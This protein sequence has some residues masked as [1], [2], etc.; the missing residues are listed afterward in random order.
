VSQLFGDSA[1]RAADES[2][3]RQTPPLVLRLLGGL[4]VGSAPLGELAA[5]RQPTSPSANAGLAGRHHVQALLAL[6][7]SSA[8]GMGRDELVELLW[9]KQGA[10]AGRNRLYHTVHLARQALSQQAWD[11]EWV[12]VRGGR[13]ALDERVWCDV[14]AL[15]RVTPHSVAG[16]SM[17]A[18]HQ[19]LSLCHGDWM[20]GLELGEAGQQVR[21]RVRQAQARVLREAVLRLRDHGDSPALRA[22]LHKLLRIEATDEPSYRELMA[23]DLHA[24]RW[25][26]VLRTYE[27]VCRELSALLG[28]RPTAAT[29][30]I[31]AAASARLQQV[32]LPPLREAGAQL[33]LGRE[34]VVQDLVQQMSAAPGV[35]NVTGLSGIG[36]TSLL[37]EVARRLAPAMPDGVQFIGM[38]DLS[39]DDTAAAACVRALGMA[40]MSPTSSTSPI[41][42]SDDLNALGQAL[43]VRQMLL[44]LDDLDAAADAPQLLQALPLPTQA[45]LVVVSRAPLLSGQAAWV[46]MQVQVPVA[47]LDVPAEHETLD[48]ARHRAGY[49]LFMLRCAS[50]GSHS[51]SL[52]WQQEVAQLVSRLDGLPLAIELAAARTTTLTP[53]EILRQIEAGQRPLEH[54]PLNLS[55]RHRSLQSSLDWTTQLLQPAVR[56]AYAA[57]SVFPAVFQHADALAI[58]PAVG[59][60]PAHMADALSELLHVGLLKPSADEQALRMLHLPREHARAIAVRLGHWAPVVQARLDELGRQLDGHLLQPESPLYTTQLRRVAELEADALALLEHARSHAAAL[61]LRILMPLCEFWITRSLT[62]V[63]LHWTERALAVAQN[64]QDADAELWFRAAQAQALQRSGRLIDAERLSQSLPPLIE[65]VSNPMGV[66]HAVAIWATALRGTGQSPRAVS[67]CQRTLQ[68]LQLK[69]QDRGF[70]TLYERLLMMRAGAAELPLD[71]AALRPRFAGSSLWMNLLDTAFV[72]GAMDED[73]GRQKAIAQEMIAASQALRQHRF[74]L[75]GTWHL[76]ACELALDRTDEAVRTLDDY[77]ICAR[78]LGWH[79]G[80]ARAQHLTALLR[81]RQGRPEAAL[82]CIT[83]V[84]QHQQQG[85]HEGL[86]VSLPLLRSRLLVQTDRTDEAMREWLAAPVAWLQRATDEHLVD[87]SETGALIAHSLGLAELKNEL[88]TAMRLL[89]GADDHIPIIRRDR[90]ARFGPGPARMSTESTQIESLRGRV[91]AAV[92]AL[93]ECLLHRGSVASH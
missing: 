85:T 17:A 93:R 81:L 28:L 39:P 50:S 45:R 16:L 10:S 15:E 86:V 13:V 31:A 8:S 67:L 20:P 87:W 12:V 70:W 49:A 52:A 36:K 7:G 3:Q 88:A 44:V 91:R 64:L 48:Q 11:D 19:L 25:H 63:V 56:A 72:M 58:A 34:S 35:W 68:Q 37:R 33:L 9:P 71:L 21:L 43:Q 90:D 73:W 61:F 54:G 30:A 18:L 69:P 46:Q 26:A 6:A 14:Q 82:P 27:A 32:E 84:E 83:V 38:G 78:G 51:P 2:L 92:T 53:G 75:S 79:K 66:A 89:D 40:P 55:P 77:Y 47:A 60:S 41:T 23:L 22:H 5:G 24:G 1:M 4:S 57:V 29:S 74:L 62:S 59:L 65:R 80:A 76:A 42:P